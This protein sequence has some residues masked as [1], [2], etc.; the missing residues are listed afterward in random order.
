VLPVGAWGGVGA[1]AALFLAGLYSF[2]SSEP[3]PLPLSFALIVIGFCGALAS[4]Y[5]LRRNRLAWGFATSINGTLGAVMIF[6]APR[7]RDLFGI[8]LS[9]AAI[10]AVLLVVITVFLAV[11]SAELEA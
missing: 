11:S 5:S 4:F 7:I 8:D 6:A 10:P 3:P 1:G 2:T 9:L